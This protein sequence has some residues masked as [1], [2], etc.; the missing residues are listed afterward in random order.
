MI[1]GFS[2]LWFQV[3]LLLAI[4]SVYEQLIEVLPTM[5]VTRLSTGML[6]CLP[7]ELPSLLVQ[8]KLS[9]IKN[10]VTSRLFQDDG[11]YISIWNDFCIETLKKFRIQKYSST[12]RLQTFAIPSDEKRRI[13]I[14][15]RNFG[16]NPGI[17]IQTEK[18]GR[19]TWKN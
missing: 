12:N 7:R 10:M 14:I 9:C 11:R 1:K 2:F 6:D 19:W 18:N 3:A 17:F 8:S 15:Y 5:E 4:S 13:E 16:W